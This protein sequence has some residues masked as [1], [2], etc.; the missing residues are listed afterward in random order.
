MVREMRMA[1]SRSY[2]K[3]ESRVRWCATEARLRLLRECSTIGI[4]VVKVAP[5]LHPKGVGGQ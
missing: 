4:K 2:E 1:C 3:L 5:H